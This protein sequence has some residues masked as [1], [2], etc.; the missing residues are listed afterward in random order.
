MAS[1]IQINTALIISSDTLLSFPVCYWH[2][3][4]KNTSLL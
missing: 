1:E 3:D 2:Q 4:T